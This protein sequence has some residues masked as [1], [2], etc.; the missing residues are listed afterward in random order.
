MSEPGSLQH[1]HQLTDEI[2]IDSDGASFFGNYPP[3]S[4]QFGPDFHRQP[5][6]ER[7]EF[8]QARR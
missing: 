1:I 6:L 8:R 7:I 4:P 5:L 3:P 2:E